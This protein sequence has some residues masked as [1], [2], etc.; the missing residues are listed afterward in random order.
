MNK[1]GVTYGKRGEVG[2][3]LYTLS[4]LSQKNFV[5]CFCS[6]LAY[7]SSE[8]NLTQ[9]NSFMQ[10]NLTNGK[11]KIYIKFKASFYLL[12]RNKMDKQRNLKLH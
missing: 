1:N 4:S 2:K 5:L 10:F 3:F 12:I 6:G 7:R 11:Y 8:L 9:D